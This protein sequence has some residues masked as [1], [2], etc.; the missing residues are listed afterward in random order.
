MTNENLI[1]N[2][3]SRSQSKMGDT[4]L[5]SSWN[6]SRNERRDLILNVL[7]GRVCLSRPIRWRS[8]FARNQFSLLVRGPYL[9]SRKTR[10]CQSVLFLSNDCSVRPVKCSTNRPVRHWIPRNTRQ[11]RESPIRLLQ[12]WH[13]SPISH[14]ILH[15]R[16]YRFIYSVDVEDV[17]NNWFVFFS[18]SFASHPTHF[19]SFLYLFG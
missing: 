4:W 15:S 3:R 12:E 1:A 14:F 11:S 6:E 19:E 2:K 10:G 17:I 16:H 13:G 18:S 5:S 8:L 7:D 9:F